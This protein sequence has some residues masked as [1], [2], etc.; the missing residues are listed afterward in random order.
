MTAKVCL[1]FLLYEVSFMKHFDVIITF[2]VDPQYAM[3]R[4]V[5]IESPPAS[6]KVNLQDNVAWK[7]TSHG[8]A[9]IALF[10]IIVF[11]LIVIII[12]LLVLLMKQSN[13]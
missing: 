6:E 8:K 13:K 9:G 7:D 12:I 4:V 3:F 10:V 5:N 2:T 11:I 1:E